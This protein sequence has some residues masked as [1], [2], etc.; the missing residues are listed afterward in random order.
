MSEIKTGVSQIDERDV[1]V[2][3][4]LAGLT[5]KVTQPLLISLGSISL[6]GLNT[7]SPET[8]ATQAALLE[9]I[10]N[11]YL[12]IASSI[13]ST[14]IRKNLTNKDNDV[15]LA[16]NSTSDHIEIIESVSSVTITENANQDDFSEQEI[17]EQS[18]ENKPETISGPHN[19]SDFESAKEKQGKSKFDQTSIEINQELDDG[20]ALLD[21][22]IELV[23]LFLSGEYL[24]TEEVKAKIPAL[25]KLDNKS[26][27]YIEFK[28]NY[29]GCRNR[30]KEYF[31]RRGFNATW[32]G[33]GKRRGRKHSLKIEIQESVSK[34]KELK[35]QEPIQAT[36][37]LKVS[38]P[39]IDTQKVLPELQK[40]P[41]KTKTDRDVERDAERF[42]SSLS[43]WIHRYAEQ[44][45]SQVIKKSEL[46]SVVSKVVDGITENMA[47][48]AIT[49]LILRSEVYSVYKGSSD[50]GYAMISTVPIETNGL[51]NGSDKKGVKLEFTEDLIEISGLIIDFVNS[52]RH[53]ELGR[54]INHILKQFESEEVDEQT[55]KFVCRRLC[56]F[57]ILTE[58][59][60]ARVGAK[61][62][63]RRS[64]QNIKTTRYLMKNADKRKRWVEDSEEVLLEILEK[65]ENNESA[66][67]IDIA[68]IE[69][70][71]D[72]VDS[73][74]QLTAG[75]K[76]SDIVNSM[77]DL[78]LK[79]DEIKAA[80]MVLKN[81]GLL[82]LIRDARTSNSPHS[83]NIR[84]PKYAVKDKN[85]RDRWRNERQKVLDEIQVLISK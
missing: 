7:Q 69:Q 70:I 29:E 3:E 21:I 5:E 44:R 10:G 20:Y 83:S 79:E 55:I 75:K 68:S 4:M 82:T 56:E 22:E 9:R 26:E 67:V 51:I 38:M 78:S 48:Q 80:L 16:T 65:I 27:E 28:S 58:K 50:N 53:L 42:A 8:V 25:A 74:R 40:T 32:D 73:E 15:S 30:I 81:A 33:Q 84:I 60:N 39:I 6:D 76:K 18:T 77:I 31:K 43:H 64:N 11:A 37:G 66:T 61:K 49:N 17:P 62:K 41:N 36:T 47:R 35:L 57:G 72:F 13:G 59:Q 1:V 71:M 2:L 46:A 24:R 14:A 45:G 19:T 34:P 85:A 12:S 23:K 54:G 52:E 63:G